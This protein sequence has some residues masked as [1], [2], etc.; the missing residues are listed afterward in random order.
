L[1][2]KEVKPEE[3]SLLIVDD[4]DDQ[5]L[6]P[7]QVNPLDLP[8]PKDVV[9]PDPIMLT[10]SKGPTQHTL[11]ELLT[12]Q[13]T[14]DKLPGSE[15]T[16]E[17][18]CKSNVLSLPSECED[19]LLAFSDIP[20]MKIDTLRGDQESNDDDPF[21]DTPIMKIDTLWGDR[22]SNNDDQT[23]YQDQVNLIKGKE[24]PKGS[25]YVS[26]RMS[27]G[28][29]EQLADVDICIDTGA[30]F[31]LCDSTFLKVHFG[32]NEALKH[33][34]HPYR[35]PNL[36]SA[37]GHVLQI[38]GKVEVKLLLGE[39]IMNLAVIVHEG[40]IGMFLL[41]SDSFYDK[42]I[43]DRGKFLAF[44]DDKHPPIPIKYE[45]VKNLVKAVGE[46]RVAPRSSALI[47][48]K[49]TDNAQFTGKEVILS[50]INE[51][52]TNVD[53]Q[54]CANHNLAST[55]LSPVRNSV[56]TIDSQG[57]AFVLV[58]N[59]T[60]DILTIL[61]DTE[62]AMV[63][64][65]S[66]EE[67]S[68]EDVN[69]INL[70]ID[71]G[72]TSL[73][74][75]E[76]PWPISALKGELSDKI[77]TN[78]IVRWD[79]L[80]DSHHHR[81]G[82]A[83]S[84]KVSTDT[85]CRSD[86]QVEPPS[87]HNI[88]YVH[89]KEERK[90]LLDGTGEGFPAPPA[91]D[92][93][94]PDEK[95]SDDPDAWLENVDHQHLTDSEWMR[96]R[97]VLVRNKE[98]FSK[99]KTEIGCCNY[100][101][102]DLPLKPG[103]G[104]LYN[105]PRPLPFKHREMAAE[106]I[107]ELLAKGVIRPSKS[108]HAT[109]IVCVKKKAVGGVVS[110]RIC[111]DLRQVN[112]H[113]VPNRFPNYWIEDAMS[114]VQGSYFRSALDFRDAFHMLVLTEESIPVTAF[115]FNNVLFEY[116]RVPFGHV[117]A[118]N[119]FC[120]LMALLCI[121]YEPSSY[122]ADDLM[123]TTKANHELSRD[124]HFDQHLKD[125][126]GMLVRIIDAGLKL[127]AAKC[128]WCYGADKPMDWLGFT[129]ENNLLRPQES[130]VK[131][132]KEFPVPTT[133]KQVISFI[134]T[135]SFYRRFIKNFAKEVQPMFNVAYAEPFEWNAAA[136]ASFERVKEIMC[137]DLVLRLPRQGEPFQ[138]YS[139]ASA[140]ALGVVLC[141]IDPKDGKSHPCAYGSR[142]FNTSELKLSI[143]CKE[144]L[145]IIYGLNLWSYYISGN[146]IQVFS[147]CRAW[148]FLKMQ[149]GASGKVSRLALLVS[150]YDIS[151]SY[152]KGTQNKAADGLSRAWEDGLTKYDDL[153]TARHPAL[154]LLTAPTLPEGEVLKFNDYMSKCD[155]YLTDHWPEIL[156]EYENQ[157]L[158]Q[159][160]DPDLINLNQKLS[161]AQ[162]RLNNL[163]KD[164]L[165]EVEY[166]N[167]VIQEA[168]IL[169]VDRD[170][171]NN[172]R[173]MQKDKL[174]PFQVN[175]DL[176]SEGFTP[177]S[178]ADDQSGSDSLVSDD[179][180]KTTDSS[181][182]A[183][184]YDIRRI[185]A[186][187]DSA[188][189]TEAFI[190]LQ[191]NDE[192]CSRKIGLIKAKDARAKSSGYFLKKN[193]LM[194]QMQTRDH[195][196]YNVVCVP[197]SLVQPLME[198]S[199][200]SLLSGHF[201]GERYA[202]NMARKYY[203]PKMKDDILDFHRKCL[204]CQYND[205]Y[206]VKHTSGYVIR[207]RWP[208]HVVH[209]D[210][211]V[212]LPRAFDGSYAILLLYDG[213][214]RFTFGIPLASEKADYIVK[215]LM[216]HF[217]AA[218]GL[219]WALHS[220]NGRNV[221]GSLIRHLALMLGVLKTSTPPYTPNANPTETMCGAV[222][223]LIRKAL[224]G[225]DKRYW[226]LCLP[227]VLNALN[228]TVHTATGY[229]PNSL[230]FG[231]YKERD[232][233]PLVP[234]DAEAANVNEYYQKVRRFQ[235][236]A[237]QIVRS[238]NERKILA[239]KAKWDT[240]ARIHSYR[241]GDY[242]LVKNLNPA[243]GPGKA[244]LRAKYVGP[245][246]VIKAY[247]SSLIVVPWTEN[248]RLEEFYRDQN[249]FRLMHRGDIKPFHTRQVSVK[250][251]KPF[252]G[253]I[254]AEQIV[255]PIMLTRFLD[256]LGIDS[257]D[258]IISE[259]DSNPS[260]PSHHSSD[261]SDSSN[262]GPPGGGNPP[263]G[264]GPNGPPSDGGGPNGPPNGPNG[265]DG[266]N[267]RPPRRRPRRTPLCSES[268]SSGFSDVDPE[269]PPEVHSVGSTP[270]PDINPVIAHGN[271]QGEE[272]DARERMFHNLDI[273]E[274]DRRL[275]RRRARFENLRENVA[276]DRARR[277]LLVELEALVASPDPHIR[278]KAEHDLRDVLDE[279][280]GNRDLNSSDESE[281]EHPQNMDIGSDDD[282]TENTLVNDPVAEDHDDQELAD[283]PDLEWDD[284]GLANP[285]PG[286]VIPGLP[287]AAAL[288]IHGRNRRDVAD[289]LA[290][291]DPQERDDLGNQ[292]MLE[293]LGFT[294][295][296]RTR[297]GRVVRP[298]VR[299]SDAEEDRRMRDE[300]EARDIVRAKRQS[301]GNVAPAESATRAVARH[302]ANLELIQARK[303]VAE[304]EAKYR[305]EAKRLSMSK[306]AEKTLT[307][308]EADRELAEARREVAEAER[309][310][311]REIVEAARLR[312]A[313][314]DAEAEAA[315][316]EAEIA[317]DLGMDREELAEA[318]QELAR[319]AAERESWAR[320]H[321]L[322]ATRA[323]IATSTPRD[324]RKSSK[325]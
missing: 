113:S 293:D 180:V 200:R 16:A 197:E 247:T 21:R 259:I 101:K 163:E 100:F 260:G 248:S 129:M 165:K 54:Y 321:S 322:N 236:L 283:M 88:Q 52:Q 157:Q 36:R 177:V 244:K 325:Q 237:F 199:H 59:D 73:M 69:Q 50:P 281:P 39:F 202:L 87:T 18:G 102:V 92:S 242:V 152:V 65:L 61:P 195:Q 264:G 209:C 121:G 305:A 257:Q 46:F 191:A 159:G 221:D 204:S 246:R 166:V 45:L 208:M 251:C 130:K 218:F 262:G 47:P 231:R 308:E 67:D 155:D 227:F 4:L 110:Y 217:V 71:A 143:P 8:L 106:T 222:A 270:P 310:H 34:Y 193:I 295:V 14:S 147:D 11:D 170:N 141:Q 230:F 29:S 213:F 24:K 284:M 288:P 324:P 174:Y 83:Q 145:A 272:R 64:L 189:T 185:V 275:L 297:T 188:F 80:Y 133:G 89:D 23:E 142:K 76:G 312:L 243:S 115:Y 276:M 292:T 84:N 318:R 118:M 66:D 28:D 132:M 19:D 277:T 298:P 184:V 136:Q 219:P 68:E 91:A 96:L 268:S 220:D 273:S 311:L 90:H 55:S 153:I 178:D 233:V 56:S 250:H 285:D 17:L 48:V 167:Q 278:R 139:D 131:A 109:N 6:T 181:F 225:S 60:D 105:K 263:G 124:Q 239:H 35:V 214:S 306:T 63:E 190:E 201:G 265:P 307:R 317:R 168:A 254:H 57:G 207:P 150:E 151:I 186:I 40:D 212:G 31:T 27:I 154:E 70:T 53:K 286:P 290:G 304:A 51:S 128:Q 161:P 112:E 99:S 111:C 148:T 2:S 313:E 72:K 7:V 280:K 9:L 216:S 234:F 192:F 3:V 303:E 253:D 79:R 235:E 98:A 172:W 266:P 316:N 269:I 232:P 97:E 205:K 228:S 274:E 125:I 15:E 85:H 252:R 108:P 164:V 140:G 13:M 104:Y 25:A 187:N 238:R 93:I 198:S 32:G 123:I 75:E 226:S 179:D 169:H 58:E 41:G 44:A 294:P 289:W 103:T 300:K 229:T 12:Q 146:P 194:R 22:E 282:F 119:A 261:S 175:E 26:C 182:K 37:S 38:L 215:K 144:L 20:I 81:D 176:I 62:L 256:S 279:I 296:T 127:V 271:I 78:V 287:G 158:A 149:S 82:M 301:M 173:R 5:E 309:L 117:C 206:P 183:A 30:D 42:L 95:L 255:D 86:G 33:I 162:Q 314:A 138:I 116:V 240:T 160:K 94:H 122:Y 10:T 320:R 134:A 120:C 135:A 299:Y 323:P 210:L 211:V 137:S 49:V 196:Y 302:R 224:C 77:P 171:P 43:F 258:E 1:R 241:E 223:M 249:V 126:E 315:R 245:F 74:S 319:F 114:K 156:K 203:W 291:V 107:S 267:D